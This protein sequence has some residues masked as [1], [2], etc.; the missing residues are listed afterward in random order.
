MG[1][2]EIMD[3]D[4]RIIL[5]EGSQYNYQILVAKDASQ[6][7]YWAAAE[8][9]RILQKMTGV[10]LPIGQDLEN[11]P[12]FG[13]YIHKAII[14]GNHP[15]LQE[16][17]VEIDWDSLGDE[18]YRITTCS[19]DIIIA[20][21]QKRGA[22]Y[23]VFSLLEKYMGVRWLTPDVE[24]IPARHCV[25]LPINLD[26]TY[27]PV[28]EYRET[29]FW[30]GLIDGTWCAHNKC[31]GHFN[32][33][34]DYQ[35]GSHKYFPFVHSFNSLVPVDKYFDEHPEYFS[36]VNGVRLRENTQLCLTND[37]VFKIA[38]KQVKDWIRKHPDT[39]IIS[40][41]QN[42]GYNPCTCDK[43][44]AL[45]AYEESHAGTLITFVNKIAAA[46]AEEYPQVS[47]DTLAYVYT[48][49]PPKYIRPLS[50]V[51]IRLCDIEC[52]FTHPLEECKAIVYP[53][54]TPAWRPKQHFSEDIKQWAK[55]H[56][57]LYIW[58]YVTNFAHPLMPFPNF[59][60]LQPNIRFFVKNNVKGL[61]EQGALWCGGGG[62]M[63]ELRN[64]V[65]AK[66]MW[67]LDCD[68]EVLVDD[69]LTGV[70]KSAAPAMRRYF[71][72]IH[73]NLANVHMGIYDPPSDVYEVKTFR[74]TVE[75]LK[76]LTRP[77]LDEANS[78]FEQMELLADDELILRRVR[79]ERLGLQY[80]ELYLED[81]S[82]PEHKM[83]VNQFFADLKSMNIVCVSE[84]RPL[85]KSYEMMRKGIMRLWDCEW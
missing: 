51:I 26:E 8:L 1:D 56:D 65:A 18:G 85:E 38:L 42:D 23:G 4:E 41:S 76:F 67:N 62:S 79:R 30:E 34:A 40:I 3:M 77:M 49:K 32:R 50:N 59:K 21:S 55:V 84:N 64:Y 78:L 28:L 39:T 66:L 58:D 57:R 7:T 71:D 74:L 47:I 81:A 73:S 14:V 6:S 15:R 52:C 35:G 69:F 46:I 75:K 63:A 13:L 11:N 43:C 48:R 2:F 68:I 27:V 70:F 10:T 25:T 61:F 20:G 45:D 17:G 16:I 5:I 53:Y 31:N 72:L 60:V 83:H 9:Q 29:S 33:V 54:D 82:L 80:I 22:M 44:R 37:D 24:H 36:E 12:Q 19:E